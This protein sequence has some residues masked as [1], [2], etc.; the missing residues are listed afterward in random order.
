M[1]FGHYLPTHFFKIIYTHKLCLVLPF[2][3]T[4]D[5]TSTCEA[6][7]RSEL[8]AELRCV[9]AVFIMP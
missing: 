9:Y 4:L 1:M 2:L 7:C 8:K 3:L 5:V 6:A